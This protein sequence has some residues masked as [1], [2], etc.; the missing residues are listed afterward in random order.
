MIGLVVWMFHEST[1]PPVYG[2]VGDPVITRTGVSLTI[3]SRP[4]DFREFRDAQQV[5]RSNAQITMQ[6]DGMNDFLMA[7]RIWPGLALVRDQRLVRRLKKG[8]TEIRFT[9]VPSGILPDTVRLRGLDH[10]QGMAILE[11]NYQYDLASAAAVLKRYVDEKITIAFKDSR[12]PVSG[13]LMSFDDRTLVVRISGEDVRNIERAHIRSIAFA[14]LPAGMLT[15]PTLVWGLENRAAAKQKFEV[16][17][18]THGLEWRADYILKLKPAA[19]APDPKGGITDTADLVGYATVTNRSGVTYENA[20][21]KLM[22]GDVNLIVPERRVLLEKR[23]VWGFGV[24]KLG[25]LGFREKSFFE[26]H[27]Y[28]LGRPTTIRDAETKQI[29]LLSGSGIKLKRGYVYDPSRNATAARVV[30]EFKNS[31]EN[32]LGKPLPKGIVRLYAPDGEG[33]DAYVSQM[34]IDHTPVNE[35]VRLMWGHAFDIACSSKQTHFHREGNR[36]DYTWRYRMRNHK[37]HDVSITIII[38]V[39]RSTY[40]AACDYRWHVRQVGLVEIDVSLKANSAATVVF[41]YSNND[42]SGGG[43][44]SPHDSDIE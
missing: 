6:T 43:L 3:M 8:L 18:L 28:T 30:S 37:D 1:T 2:E 11:Q 9:G 7:R 5:R 29:E 12:K 4:E 17:Y 44:T 27:L 40:K 14:N 38:H 36:R 31:K 33:V 23:Y 41:S 25:G 24:V 34:S 10:P 16:A 22:A 32:G 39:P 21:L 42:T 20:E 19:E 13:V 15:R 26:Y 35:K